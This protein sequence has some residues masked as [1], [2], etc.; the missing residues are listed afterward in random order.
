MDTPELVLSAIAIT[1]ILILVTLVVIARNLRDTSGQRIARSI[2]DAVERLGTATRHFTEVNA[3]LALTEQFQD[4]PD[5]VAKLNEY[6]RQ[7]VAAALMT[8]INGVASDIKT[9]Q[10]ELAHDR[11][12]VAQSYTSHQAD[13]N[14]N[15]QMLLHLEQELTRLH[16]LN[17]QLGTTLTSVS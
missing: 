2:D 13:V 3:V 11:K 9:V 6:S 16:E 17:H 12:M 14:R 7:T 5:L 4:R 8:R 1:A 15:E 10:S